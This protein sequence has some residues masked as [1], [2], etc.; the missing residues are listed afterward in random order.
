MAKIDR[1]EDMDVWKKSMDLCNKIYIVTNEKKFSN[2]FALRDQVRKSAISI[3]SN[4][5][6]GFERES[7]NQFIYFLL[8]AK[9]SAGELRTQ[10]Y[11]AY[12]CNYIDN[13]KKNEL[14][15]NL[16]EISKLLGGFI[17]YLRSIKKQ[18][19]TLQKQFS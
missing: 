14:I 15:D 3:P 6:E 19:T 2:D 11:I 12:N 7:N 4:I 16:I 8:I 10:I 13:I 9:A 5:A 17:A 1:F 18:A